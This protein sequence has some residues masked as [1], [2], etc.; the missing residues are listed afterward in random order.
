MTKDN[1]M[2]PNDHKDYCCFIDK[3][4]KPFKIDKDDDKTQHYMIYY[5]HH[6]QHTVISYLQQETGK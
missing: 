5:Y 3:D 1:Y 4:Y 6:Y 2:D